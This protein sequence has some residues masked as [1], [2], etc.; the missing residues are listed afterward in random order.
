MAGYQ[1][2]LHLPA[3][4]TATA[5]R[6]VWHVCAQNSFSSTSPELQLALQRQV[7]ATCPVL[8]LMHRYQEDQRQSAEPGSLTGHI[9]DSVIGDV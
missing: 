8:T 4:S 1:V 5:D 2:C 7:L 3:L 6:S 9:S